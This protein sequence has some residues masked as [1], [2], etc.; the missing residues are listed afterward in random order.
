MDAPSASFCCT[1]RV[2]PASAGTIMV[3]AAGIL[4]ART[5][6]GIIMADD[7][8][9][10]GKQV[11]RRCAP[12]SAPPRLFQR[13]CQS[14]PEHARVNP[15]GIG[16]R[17]QRSA[18]YAHLC[19]TLLCDPGDYSAELFCTGAGSGGRGLT[20]PG[21]A[22]SK[23]L[24]AGLRRAGSWPLSESSMSRSSSRRSRERNTMWVSSV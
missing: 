2:H 9:M 6:G 18:E 5:R 22:M 7:G 16:E 23:P 15:H 4:A 19:A 10:Q 8:R 24:A 21:G 13:R 1:L 14:P 12:F 17:P 11:A 20:G 3:A